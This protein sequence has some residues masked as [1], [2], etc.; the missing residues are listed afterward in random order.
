M[1]ATVRSDQQSRGVAMIE[2]VRLEME[3]EE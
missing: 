1:L 3:A 2:M